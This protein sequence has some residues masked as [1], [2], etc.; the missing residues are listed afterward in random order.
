[1]IPSSK[2]LCTR[3]H[4]AALAALALVVAGGNASAAPIAR[5]TNN[6][7]Y[8]TAGGVDASGCVWLYLSAWRSG[9]NAAPQTS[10]YYE[11]FDACAGQS[12]GFGSGLIP[13]TALR[14]GSKSITLSVRV[15]TTATFYT[16][17]PTGTITLTVR[18][19]GLGE[20]T[21]SGHTTSVFPGAVVKA[22]GS[23]TYK[24]AAAAGSVL[25]TSFDRLEGEIGEG[26]DKQIEFQRN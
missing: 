22:H 10:L 5:T 11:M 4:A 2:A 13:N 6:G 21:Y 23:W 24:A 17:G 8:A 1:M 26:R 7:A 20:F 25:A 12:V 16:E 19:S 18:P 3:I 14:V 15:A 9:T